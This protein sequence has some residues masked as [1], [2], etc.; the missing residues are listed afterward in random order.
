MGRSLAF[1]ES[2][3]LALAQLSMRQLVLAMSGLIQTPVSSSKICK[4]Q[5]VFCQ[6]HRKRC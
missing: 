3:A 6:T 1:T 5:F 2:L 4:L